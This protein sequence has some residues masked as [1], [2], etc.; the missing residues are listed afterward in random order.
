MCHLREFFIVQHMREKEDKKT[1]LITIPK[2]HVQECVLDLA[3]E[4]RAYDDLK[5]ANPK[6]SW[7]NMERVICERISGQEI[8]FLSKSCQ[9]ISKNI[10]RVFVLLNVHF[11]IDHLLSVEQQ[12]LGASGHCR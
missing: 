6:V 11:L 5:T 3:G 12:Q 10:S 1:A 8:M 4:E 2:F 9:V 7:Q